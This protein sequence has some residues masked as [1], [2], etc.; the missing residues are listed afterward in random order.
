MTTATSR[1]ATGTILAPQKKVTP[2]ATAARHHCV[3]RA[4]SFS[5]R[6]SPSWDVACLALVHRRRWAACARALLSFAMLTRGVVRAGEDESGG[7]AGHVS[8]G[9][10]C[11]NA[12]HRTPRQPAT[13]L[14]GQHECMPSP[15]SPV[16]LPCKSAHSTS[17]SQH[18]QHRTMRC[19]PAT[20]DRGGA[21]S[22]LSLSCARVYYAQPV[23][24]RALCWLC[25]R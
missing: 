14:F 18:S 21:A 13:T 16:R 3:L 11:T 19:E 9:L 22:T 1:F 5:A 8:S 24:R 25:G 2:P 17:S 15:C 4:D 23:G 20:G 10:K 12:F 6:F 7:H